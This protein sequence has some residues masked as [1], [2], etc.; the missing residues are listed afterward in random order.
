M[1]RTIA[2]ASTAALLGAAGLA[3]QPPASQ[4]PTTPPAGQPPAG[5]PPATPKPAQPAQPKEEKKAEI[6]LKVGDPAP[7]LKIDEWLKGDSITAME[8]NKTYVLVF[9]ATTDNQSVDEIPHLTD[10][11]KRYKDIVIVG[12]AGPGRGE[13]TGD[14]TIDRVDKFVKD[15]G[16]KI[17]YRIGFDADGETFKPYMDG[18]NRNK[19]PTAF[20]VDGTTKVAWIGHPKDLDK[21]LDRMMAVT[22][23]PKPKDKE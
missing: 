3:A 21:E 20:V 9:W 7:A 13:A 19:L 11:Q 5:Q 22:P 23:A 15:M 8:K 1:K 18:A 10:L 16:T 6:K 4:P 12:I 17:G 14:L 2:I